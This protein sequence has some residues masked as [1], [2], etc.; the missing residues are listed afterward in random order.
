MILWVLGYPFG[1]FH[2]VRVTVW[3]FDLASHAAVS[4]PSKWRPRENI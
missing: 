1:K 3:P 2:V 4:Q